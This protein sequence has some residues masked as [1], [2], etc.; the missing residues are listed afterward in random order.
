M[1]LQVWLAAFVLSACAYTPGHYE[2]EPLAENSYR[3]ALS[4][5][6]IAPLTQST[7]SEFLP[8]EL[9]GFLQQLQNDNLDLH[10]ARLRVERAREVLRSAQA[11]R[12]PRAS[13]S[14][15]NADNY[16][17][18][19]HIGDSSDL[20]F[21][22]SYTIDLWGERAANIHQREVQLS[23]ARWEA[24]ASLISLQAQFIRTY[25]D[26]LSLQTLIGVAEQNLAASEKLLELFQL[27][28]DLG[29][30]SGLELHQQ[31]N[32]V[33][34]AR[35]KQIELQNELAVNRRALAIMLG[36]LDLQVPELNAG[37]DDITLPGVAA[38]QSAQLLQ[39]RPDIQ[40]ATLALAENEALIHQA[41]TA[42]WPD[43]TLSL[44]WGIDDILAGGSDWAGSIR[45]A[46]S[47]LLFDGGQTRAQIRLAELDADIDYASYRYTVADAY[48]DAIDQLENQRLREQQLK[49]AQDK[50]ANNRALYDIA[51]ARYEAGD[52]D[53]LDLLLAQ[54]SWFSAKEELVSSKLNYLLALV[55]VYEAMGAT[56]ELAETVAED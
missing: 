7:W 55:N 26:T 9:K 6:P 11:E 54:Q 5:R 44:N 43:L 18:S 51:R 17:D 37:F 40:M 45:E 23:L 52:A 22:A 13:T 8:A 25:F 31:R 3:D 32:L 24:R 50:Y 38:V 16:N 39:Q 12:W 33:L 42:R 21:S 14:L 27:T 19:G 53:F 47:L 29:G 48:R 2:P 46:A 36:R 56:P 1:K 41:K 49:I 15:S 20:T 34:S 30:V 35:N 4:G 28:Y 10:M